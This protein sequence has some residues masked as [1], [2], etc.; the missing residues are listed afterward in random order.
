MNPLELTKIHFLK[1]MGSSDLLAGRCL[2]FF[3]VWHYLY[4]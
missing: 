3:G 1:L 2:T 4:I